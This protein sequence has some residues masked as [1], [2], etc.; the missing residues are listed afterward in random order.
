[1]QFEKRYQTLGFLKKLRLSFISI[2]DSSSITVNNL[3]IRSDT[4]QI[5]NVFGNDYAFNQFNADTYLMTYG[6][7]G[8]W[9]FVDSFH[10]I[11]E[12]VIESK[13]ITPK[14]PDN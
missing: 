10:K 14:F 4:S 5:I 9:F 2:N 3:S 11:K 8:I 6:Q 1:M 7:E 13:I 12:I